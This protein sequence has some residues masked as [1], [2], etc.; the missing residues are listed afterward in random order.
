MSDQTDPVHGSY[1]AFYGVVRTY[2]GVPLASTREEVA[3]ADVV[4][5]GA[6]FDEGVSY[7][8]GTRFGPQAVRTAEDVN[9]PGERPSMH[10]GIDPLAEL[11][12]VDWGD[13]DVIASNLPR[14]HALLVEAT[15]AALAMST[16]PVVIGGDH[17][18]SHAML[19]AM[20]G[21]F[22]VDGY[23]VIH[24]DTHAD[25]GIPEEGEPPHGTPF[26]AAI[27]KGHLNGANIFQIGLRGTWPGPELFQ[28]MREQGM[29]WATMDEV[30]DRGIMDVVLEA[31]HHARARAPRTYLTVDIDVL[32]PAYAPGTGTPEP[33]GLTT[34]ELFRAV[35]TITSELDI[36]AFDLVEVS[37][38]YDHADVTAMAGQRTILEALNGIAL[39]HAGRSAQHERP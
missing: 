13:I 15:A 31:I 12:I 25:T 1:H 37:P 24:F 27:E 2:C 34:R 35:R 11:K 4:I 28:W 17:S 26:R 33:G 7:R 39:R 30:E 18:L 6:P 10:A 14:S 16:I 38:P 36:A 8:P 9:Q 3:A 20:H 22:G 21:Q 32:D 5:I 29:Q 19:Q 23:S